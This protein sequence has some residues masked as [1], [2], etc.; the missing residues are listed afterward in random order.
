MGTDTLIIDT[1][2]HVAETYD[3]W[4]S[5]MPKKYLDEAPCATKD[6]KGMLRWR[7]GDRWVQPV[8]MLSVAGWREYF[9]SFPPTLEEADP[10]CYDPVARLQRM[11]EY[12]IRAA[13]LY[14]NIIAFETYAFLMLKDEGLRLACVQASNDWLIDFASTDRSRFVP[15]CML[16]F[17]DVDQCV[18]EM[19]RCAD[20]G[21]S[22]V[23]WAVTFDRI[24]LPHG[25]DPYWDPV[26]A[27]ARD[28]DMSI[29]L[30]AA[31]ATTTKEFW[32]VRDR[33][34]GFFV[35]PGDAASTDGTKAAGM[36]LGIADAFM[37]NA[38]QIESLI[39]RGV[40]TRFPEV[41]F[42]SVESGFGYVPYLLESLDWNVKNLF[43]PDKYDG[44]PSDIF[45]RQIYA[46]FWFE[47]GPLSQLS[48]YPD[49][50]MYST[51]FPH[52]TSVSPGPSSPALVPSTAVDEQLKGIPEALR[53]KVLHETAARLYKIA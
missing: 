22:A 42:V 17:W 46:T 1:D 32:D 5:R 13:V 11:D 51:D 4:T 53:R 9:P 3:V 43:P 29:N 19:Q 25:T 35:N 47:Q 20:R 40:C 37:V 33:A 24:G 8:G 2:T 52:P 6:P 7:V 30:H 49:N 31:I 48:L 36:N 45:R 50:V 12:G 18:A 26:Y 34:L 28:L 27:A 23:L 15:T 10:A 21:V 39:T 14:P 16:P 41:N 38:N 44:L